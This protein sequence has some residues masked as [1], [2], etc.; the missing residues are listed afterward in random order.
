MISRSC[1]DP[2]MG[3]ALCMKQY[4]YLYDWMTCKSYDTY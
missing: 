3:E 4:W 1:G 2:L